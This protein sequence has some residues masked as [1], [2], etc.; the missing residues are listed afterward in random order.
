MSDAAEKFVRIFAFMLAACISPLSMA[1]PLSAQTTISTGSIVG[2][3]SDPSGAVISGADVTITNRATGQSVHLTTNSSGAFNSGAL[4]PGDYKALIAS[5]SFRSAEVPTTVLL[6]NTAT[7]NVSLQLG[8]EKQVVEV[9]STALRVNTEQAAVQGVLNAEQIENLP[10]NGH[11]FLD[12]A[13]L[14]PGVQIQDGA[15]FGIG[16]DGYSSISIGGRFGR[17][18]RIEVDGL[19]VSD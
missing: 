16:K 13:Q 1:H 17:T 10:V 18:A 14:E 7:V 11:N 9:Q 3:V 15:N 12:L 2:T 6:G 5:A 8:N 4:I 19:D